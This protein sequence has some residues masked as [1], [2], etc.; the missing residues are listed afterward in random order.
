VE[1]SRRRALILASIDPAAMRGL[2][3][4]A[5]HQPVVRRS[6][7]DVRYVDHTD[8]ANLRLQAYPEPIDLD[9]I[10]EVDIV[11]AAEPLAQAVGDPVDYIVASHVIE[12][13]PDLV[14]WLHDL[15]GVLKR[16]GVLSLVVPDK[17]F[18][19]DLRRN[20]STIGEVA[21]A[22]LSGYRQPSIRQTFDHCFSA[23]VVDPRQAWD[24]D[25]SGDA[26][27]KIVGD[28]VALPLAWNQAKALVREPRYIDSHCWVFTPQSFLGLLDLLAQLQLLP[29]KVASFTETERGEIEFFVQLRPADPAAVQDIRASIARFVAPEPNRGEQRLQA[30]EASVSWRLTA[31]LRALRR[32]L[33]GR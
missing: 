22:Y 14:G 16:G 12:H 11:W 33:T 27:A 23:V 18:T 13:V 25:L 30:V 29:F 3:I 8:A 17:R 7:G 32:R 20:P 1:P 19:F 31:P 10:V 15:A 4:G 28:D 2:E 24:R 26:L 5:L 6:D 9:A 21:E